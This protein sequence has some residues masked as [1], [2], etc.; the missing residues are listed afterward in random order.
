MSKCKSCG[1]EILWIK[2]QSGKA[3][4]VD[5]KQVMYWKKQKG[6]EKVVTPNGEVVSCELVGDLQNATGIGYVSHFST[7]PF[8]GQHR[9]G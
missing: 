3:M 2:M 5:P 7:C 1:A 9:R 6:S 8:A 4:P